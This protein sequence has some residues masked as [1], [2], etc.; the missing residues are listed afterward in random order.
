MTAGRPGRCLGDRIVDLADDRLDPAA[1][2]R[3]YAHVALCPP[4]RAALEAQRAVRS[5][6]AESGEAPVEASDD[7]IARLRAVAAESPAADVASIPVQPA[8]GRVPAGAAGVRPGVAATTTR[9]SGARR[10]HRSRIALAS[11]AG[12]AALAVVA[13]VGGGSAAVSGPSRPAPAIAPVVDRLTVAHETS[14]DRMPFSGPR[15][16]T[17]AFGAPSG[18]TSSRP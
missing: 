12:A 5:T 18:S 11:A 14:T 3:A 4:C 1:A 17:A 9:P 10:R 16:V 8:A 13:A 7:L 6:L 2:E 15:I